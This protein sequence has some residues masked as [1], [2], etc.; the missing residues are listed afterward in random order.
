MDGRQNGER[1]RPRK[2]TITDVASLAGVSTKTVSRVLNGEATV[3]SETRDR[4]R[5]AMTLLQ[6]R[7]NSPGRML[8]GRKTYLLGLIYNANS[9]YIT[10]IQNGA[11]QACRSEHYDLLIHPCAYTDPALMGELRYLIES[12]RVDGLLLIP[13]I[14]DL[15]AV[16]ELMDEI[17]APN[18]IISPASPTASGWT[19]GT[20]D[21]EVS[22]GVV[23][24]LAD[25]GHER[26]AFVQ[27]HPDH[28]AMAS[29]YDGFL[30]GLRAC[31]LRI[32]SRMVMR[33]DNTAAS[34][35][36][37]GR[38]LLGRKR[39]PT[40]IF[41]AND[42]MASGVMRAAHE[43][44]LSIPEDISL[45]GFDD[46]PLAS[47]LYPSLTTVRQPLQEMA[48]LA[49]EL[50]IRR[51]RGGEPEDDGQRTMNSQ[52]IVRESTGPAPVEDGLQR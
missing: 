34:G 18:V 45:A 27:A 39:R 20:N 17:D 49:G 10:S 30:D 26:I 24:H 3:R 22:A 2:A 19:V 6:Y 21:R 50:L 38:K 28:L 25:L 23:K 11:L 40:A 14:S 43:A 51:L 15:P 9:S 48:C 5:E 4:I 7:P 16:M 13:P 1:K 52:I 33:G 44:G 36:E 42:H 29:R 31:D 46:I 12:P 41:C 47:Q 8:A 32:D 37:C 35:L